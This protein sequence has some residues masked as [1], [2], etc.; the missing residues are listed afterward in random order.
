MT[1]PVC[2][3]P[4]ALRLNAGAGLKMNNHNHHLP[5]DL[6]ARPAEADTKAN[7]EPLNTLNQVRALV[8]DAA[9]PLTTILN[10]AEI[11]AHHDAL[12][13]ELLEDIQVIL[14][15]AVNLKDIFQVLRQKL[16]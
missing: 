11:L 13:E 5:D 4:E 16:H 2:Y 3:E 9:Q 1:L 7:E 10:L 6:A 8:H 12:N 15:E 14:N